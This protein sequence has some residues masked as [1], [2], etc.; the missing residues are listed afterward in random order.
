MTRILV[1]DDSL[2]VRKAL[3]IILKPH[4]Y[5]V[6]MA[7]SGEAALDVLDEHKADLVI[8]DVLMPGMSGFELCEQLM[9]DSER[10]GMP[11]IL[12]SGIV[13]DEEQTKARSV[14]AFGLVKKPF[15]ADDLLPTV[16]AAL[17]S[18]PEPV[19]AATVPGVSKAVTRLDGLLAELAAKQGVL[20]VLLVSRDG[21]VVSRH[22]VPLADADTAAHYFRFF[23]NTA[24]VL[25]TRLSDEF[26]GALLEYG[27]RAVLVSSLAD[28]H[29]LAVVLRDAGAASMAKYVI[30][31]QRPQ[32][33]AALAGA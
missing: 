10:G 3:E 22:G 14:G 9:R 21:T 12:I 13:S 33:E 25:G 19:A 18:K 24:S 23:A 6:R 11:V 7:D 17:A 29:A 8:A 1:V 31:G 15:K 30:K 4:S 26:Q 27:S 16:R 32:F 28:G 2:S 20:S 5:D